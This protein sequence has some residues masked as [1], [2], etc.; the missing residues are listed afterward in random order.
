MNYCYEQH[1]CTERLIVLCKFGT[2][3]MND[4]IINLQVQLSLAITL[5]LTGH[6]VH[7]ERML[8][9]GRTPA[10][11]RVT[12]TQVMVCAR[13]GWSAVAF[14]ACYSHSIWAWSKQVLKFLPGMS[15]KHVPVNADKTSFEW[16]QASE[17]STAA[18]S[19]VC[20][21]VMHFS[22]AFVITLFHLDRNWLHDN[23][24]NNNYT[25]HF[26]VLR[27]SRSQTWEEHPAV[28]MQ[29]DLMKSTANVRHRWSFT[30]ERNT[31]MAQRFSDGT[32]LLE[33]PLDNETLAVPS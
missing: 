31:D 22:A 15:S 14:W 20:D 1:E 4:R 25:H 27:P 6:G 19:T 13:F 10:D 26:N 7:V 24:F 17:L 16:H 11:T 2:T 33:T 32:V 18:N 21:L 29:R 8:L 3:H 23:N 9:I 12:H 28:K 5:N 30:R